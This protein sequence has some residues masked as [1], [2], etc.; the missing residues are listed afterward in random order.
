MKSH[1]F[2]A[3][4]FLDLFAIALIIPFLTDYVVAVGY[5]SSDVGWIASIYG[6]MQ[7]ISLPAFSY[8]M[9]TFGKRKM[10]L[11]SVFGT[12]MALFFN[13]AAVACLV[14][15]EN[16]I[17]SKKHLFLAYRFISGS[18]RQTISIALAMAFDDAGVCGAARAKASSTVQ[19]T[20]S[21]AF[22]VAPWLGGI[23]V[24][25]IGLETH[26]LV[27][28]VVSF[29][30]GIVMLIATMDYKDEKSSSIEISK[31][32]N[33]SSSLSRLWSSIRLMFWDSSRDARLLVLAM[34]ASSA[35]E[36]GLQFVNSSYLKSR[37]GLTSSQ[38]GFCISLTSALRV[39]AQLVGVRGILAITKSPR[40]IV[41]ILA[42]T[43]SLLGMC[44]LAFAQDFWWYIF[45]VVIFSATSAVVDSFSKACLSLHFA[46]S[47]ALVATFFSSVDGANR[48]LMPLMNSFLVNNFEGSTSAPLYFGSAV[49]IFCSLCHTFGS[50]A[51][52]MENDKDL[53][54]N[55]KKVE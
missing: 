6:T 54:K 51:T 5:S 53:E 11:V 33:D 3:A 43:A 18:V 10:I 32:K 8:F 41:L 45:G 38:V 48:M 55:G 1:L 24:D 31:S 46:S 52:N 42:W 14:D 34:F 15:D 9:E 36:I 12:A 22:V 50:T 30:A 23:S 17:V 2:L 21:I 19:A 47:T 16:A 44:Q 27:S 20:V 29:L 13:Y 49:S 26:A 25:K 7:T 39:V 35:A 28:T 4:V 40:N 37:F